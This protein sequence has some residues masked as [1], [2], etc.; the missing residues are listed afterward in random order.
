MLYFRCPTCKTVLADK[1]IPYEE[2]IKKICADKKLSDDEKNIKKMQ[3]LDDLQVIRYCC[4]MRMITY[5][6][7]IEI[8][9]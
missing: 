5:V 2:A 1:Q 6:K 7:L 4:R 8:V 9:K 3:V